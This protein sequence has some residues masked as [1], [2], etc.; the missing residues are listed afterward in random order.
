ML[1]NI[2]FYNKTLHPP[3]GPTPLNLT[4]GLC[5]PAS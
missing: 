1:I 3:G 5:M 4:E 2:N